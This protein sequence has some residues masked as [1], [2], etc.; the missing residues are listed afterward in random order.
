[1][2]FTKTD[3]QA[4]QIL[5]SL[6]LRGYSFADVFDIFNGDDLILVLARK[7]QNNIT[8]SKKYVKNNEINNRNQY[9]N[10]L[11]EKTKINEIIE[12]LEHTIEHLSN[13]KNNTERC[14]NLI[15][16]LKCDIRE[17]KY[18]TAPCYEKIIIPKK[19][20]TCTLYKS[21]ENCSRKKLQNSKLDEK[22]LIRQKDS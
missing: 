17:I 8:T 1:M 22:L 14:K 7:I 20:K 10:I 15:I 6:Y 5:F 13:K 4:T 18:I 19:I 16:Q 3:K 21:F 9:I 2:I 11:N 12:K